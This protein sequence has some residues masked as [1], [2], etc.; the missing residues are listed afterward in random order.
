MGK[1]RYQ[2]ANVNEV[3]INYVAKLIFDE[4][5]KTD[6]EKFLEKQKQKLFR[7]LEILFG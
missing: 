4:W 2:R 5:V 3:W 7:L 6:L 1:V